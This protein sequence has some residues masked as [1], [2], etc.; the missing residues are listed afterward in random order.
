MFGLSHHRAE[1][2]PPD[3]HQC[4]DNTDPDRPPYIAFRFSGLLATIRR[5]SFGPIW[6]M[7]FT[8]C[9]DVSGWALIGSPQRPERLLRVCF[10]LRSILSRYHT[11]AV[12][13]RKTAR[14]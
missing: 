12:L 4:D 13:I 6:K 9:S 14:H 3:D 8:S 7:P 10:A 1:Y 11:E 5:M 2:Q